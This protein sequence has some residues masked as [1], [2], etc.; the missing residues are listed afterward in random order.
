MV[1]RRAAVL[2]T[3]VAATIVTAVPA[4]AATIWTDWTAATSGSP[5]SA[6]GALGAV[7][8]TYTGDLFLAT[9]DGSSQL[10]APDSSFVGGNVT[11]SPAAV[12][13]DLRMNGIFF[14]GPNSIR[15]SA[16]VVN[17]FIAFWSLGSPF[18]VAAFTFTETPTLQAG[19]PNA[20][21]LGG[22]SIDVT[23]NVVSGM[24]GNGVVQ[25]MGIF[26]SLTWSA[27]PDIFYAFTVG[28]NSL[29]PAPVPEPASLVLV[30]VGLAGLVWRRRR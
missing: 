3:L 1:S 7:G 12:G 20:L 24:N 27:T 4:R 6:T 5:G 8:V 29:A 23:G 17:P 25:F 13:D 22:G 19:G 28:T 15:F 11:D 21:P 2:A 18:T 26:T 16:P 10:W 30:G 14:S 9:L